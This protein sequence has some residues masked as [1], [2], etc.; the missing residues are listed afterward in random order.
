[1]DTLSALYFKHSFSL[2]SQDNHPHT[3]SLAYDMSIIA[4]TKLTYGIVTFFPTH[5]SSPALFP[6]PGKLGIHISSLQ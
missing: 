1:M 2:F 3:L 5:A 4:A 6:S